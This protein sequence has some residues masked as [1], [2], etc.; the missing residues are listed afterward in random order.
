MFF[1]WGIFD[2]EWMANG[3][4][5]LSDVQGTPNLNP[6]SRGHC[7]CF[8]RHILLIRSTAST[9]VVSLHGNFELKIQ[10]SRSESL[11]LLLGERGTNFSNKT[12]FSCWVLVAQWF[13]AFECC[14]LD[15]IRRQLIFLLSYFLVWFSRLERALY[16]SLSHSC[17]SLHFLLSTVRFIGTRNAHVGHTVLMANN[18]ALSVTNGFL[19]DVLFSFERLE[20]ATFCNWTANAVPYAR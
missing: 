11:G 5:K 9:P 6:R 20:S 16:E 2:L 13:K 19:V 12:W 15:P 8:Q 4:N 3:N 14:G 7:V 18:W 10:R 1:L 17:S